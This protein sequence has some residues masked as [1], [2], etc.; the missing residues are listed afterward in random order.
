MRKHDDFGAACEAR[1]VV[2]ILSA[3]ALD[4]TPSVVRVRGGRREVTE[5]PYAEAVEHLG[6]FYL[7]EAPDLATLLELATALP[8]YD[9]QISPVGEA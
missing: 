4:G 5:G 8:A 1:E 3:E 2:S 7:V 9:L 6:G